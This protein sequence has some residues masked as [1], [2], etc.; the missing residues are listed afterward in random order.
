M[1]E[2]SSF[3]YKQCMLNNTLVSPYTQTS[4]GKATAIHAN[5]PSTLPQLDPTIKKD[6]NY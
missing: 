2:S 5:S 3:F 1:M 6:K 4:E